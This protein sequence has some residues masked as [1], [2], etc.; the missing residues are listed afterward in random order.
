M[1]PRS[2]MISS[3]PPP[4]GF[5]SP[6]TPYRSK[7]GPRVQGPPRLY[8]DRPVPRL[9]PPLGPVLLSSDESCKRLRPP[10]PPV[11][12]PL[13][14]VKG[15]TTGRPQE[16]HRGLPC[17]PYPRPPSRTTPSRLHLPMEGHELQ[18]DRTSASVSPPMSLAS[19]PPRMSLSILS[20]PFSVR[21]PRCDDT[22][23]H[24]RAKWNHGRGS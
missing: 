7:A 5:V 20:M 6:P 16:Q 21:L 15:S 10:G 22:G 18:T 24:P 2:L 13:K 23:R 11:R 14:L 1:P 8:S 17:R 3:T 19:S 4:A 12:P 9:R